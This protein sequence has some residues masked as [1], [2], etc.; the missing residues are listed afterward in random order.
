MLD[1]AG[2]LGQAIGVQRGTCCDQCTPGLEEDQVKVL[3][4][5]DCPPVTVK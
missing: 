3:K 4:A 5:E 1:G 2:P